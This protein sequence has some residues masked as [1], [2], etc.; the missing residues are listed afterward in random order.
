MGLVDQVG[1]Q[2]VRHQ[3]VQDWGDHHLHRHLRYQDLDHSEVLL[4][5]QVHSNHP[6]RCYLVEHHPQDCY[7]HICDVDKARPHHQDNHLDLD[8]RIP[9][10]KVSDCQCHVVA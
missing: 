4:H 8:W 1:L 3:G 7:R 9:E 2:G 6:G 10:E 5:H